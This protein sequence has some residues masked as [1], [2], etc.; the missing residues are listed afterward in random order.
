[1]KI[2]DLIEALLEAKAEHGDI[3]VHVTDPNGERAALEFD[4]IN[5]EDD[6]DVAGEK[7]M[8]LYIG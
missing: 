7:H 3:Y 4:W 2:S 6:S 1:M 5:V 8:T